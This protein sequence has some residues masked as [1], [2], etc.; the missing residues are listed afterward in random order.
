MH[1]QPPCIRFFIMYL[2]VLEEKMVTYF[3][4]SR[5][6]KNLYSICADADW[7]TAPPQNSMEGSSAWTHVISSLKFLIYLILKYLLMAFTYAV[8]NTI[9]FLRNIIN[10]KQSALDLKLS[11][12]IKQY[13][14]RNL[15]EGST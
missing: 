6:E 9:G 2:T 15:Y 1:P 3:G 10:K 4:K 13:V 5:K 11:R 14:E 7:P 8:E 12:R